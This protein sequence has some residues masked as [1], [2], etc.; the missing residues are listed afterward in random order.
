MVWDSNLKPSQRLA[1]VG[2]I[3][4]QSSAGALH[5]GWIDASQAFNFLATVQVGALGVAATVDAK[6]EQATSSGGA[7]IKD[8]PNKAITQLTKAAAQDN[9][10]VLIN[11]RQDELDFN[12]GFN[13]FRLTLTPG[14]A[15]SLLGGAVQQLDSRFQPAP[16]DATV[17][18]VV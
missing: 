17:L 15:A 9:S 12:N 11:L 6:L 13:W 2:I 1:L 14:T 5:S 18:Q 16:Q 10:E 7:G 8:V 3:P 4:P